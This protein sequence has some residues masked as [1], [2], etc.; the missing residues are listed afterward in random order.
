MRLNNNMNQP[1]F[2]YPQSSLRLN[3]QPKSTHGGTQ[4]FSSICSRGWPCGTSMRGE[5]LGLVEAQ[6]LSIREY[7]DREAGVGGLVSRGRRDVMGGGWFR[8]EMRKG[9]NI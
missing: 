5:T 2:A 3:H 8:E 9:D 6:C 1:D 4:G 7:Q